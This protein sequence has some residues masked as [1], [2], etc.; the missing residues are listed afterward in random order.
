[1]EPFHF[2]PASTETPT[3]ETTTVWWHKNS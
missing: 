3:T 2:G 1:M